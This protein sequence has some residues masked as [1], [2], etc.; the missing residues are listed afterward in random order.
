MSGHILIVWQDASC[1]LNGLPPL[2]F[3]PFHCILTFGGYARA[4]CGFPLCFS[5]CPPC[6]LW[7]TP[8]PFLCVLCVLCGFSLCFSP[9]F[10]SLFVSPRLWRGAGGEVPLNRLCL[11]VI[12]EAKCPIPLRH[13]CPFFID[14][15]LRRHPSHI[16][17]IRIV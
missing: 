17:E 11:P 2:L 12:Q 10:I 3:V 16:H 5:M 14:L 15:V 13:I 7:L 1:L 4:L 6:P 8:L 9:Q